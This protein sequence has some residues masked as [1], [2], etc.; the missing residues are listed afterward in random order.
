VGVTVALP[1]SASL[2]DQAP[3]AA[4]ELAWVDDHVSTLCSPTVTAVGFALRTR[5]GFGVVAAVTVSCT[6]CGP[7]V[8]MGDG[9]VQDKRYV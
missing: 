2:P 8:K 4:Q 9:N 6:D 3:L 7:T 1:E 5:V